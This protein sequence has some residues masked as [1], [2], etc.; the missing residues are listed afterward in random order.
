MPALNTLLLAA[1]KSLRIA[2]IANGLPKPLM[3]IANEAIIFR[4]LRWINRFAQPNPVWINL[5]YK[6]K[7]MQR[8]IEN[9]SKQI[10]NLQIKFVYEKNIMGTAGALKNISNQTSKDSHTLV[11][12]ADN[13]FNFDLNDFIETHYRKKNKVTIAVFDDRLNTHTG[14]AGG[15]ALLDNHLY[16]TEFVEG[17]NGI[18]SPYVNAGVYLLAPEIIDHIPSDQFCD[19]GKDIFPKLLRENVPLNSYIIDGYC[20]GL[21]TPECFVVANKLIEQKKIVIL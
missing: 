18:L 11:I 21:D 2:K 20:L 16:I 17:K 9:F 8:K 13:L 1:G 10:S 6:H 5:H 14:I 15:K 3:P 4:N 12:Y 19:F 7:L